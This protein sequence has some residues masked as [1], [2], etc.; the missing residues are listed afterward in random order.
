MIEI[1]SKLSGIFKISGLP[2][3]LLMSVN[4]TKV[5]IK[6]EK[7]FKIEDN[8]PGDNFPYIVLSQVI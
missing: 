2:L 3:F 1:L 7:K 4:L 5:N 8:V 6:E